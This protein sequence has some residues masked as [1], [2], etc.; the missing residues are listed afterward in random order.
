V[1][2]KHVDGTA[3][4]VE[5]SVPVCRCGSEDAEERYSLG[6][7]AGVWCAPCWKTSGYRDEG[8]SGFDPLD[9]GEAYEEDDY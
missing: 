8:P 3:R 1:S 9:A 7:Y 4:E 2:Y 6:I 5:R